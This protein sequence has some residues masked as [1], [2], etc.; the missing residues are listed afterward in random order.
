MTAAA[1]SPSQSRRPPQ[2]NVT[3]PFHMA[4]T[5]PEFAKTKARRGLLSTSRI[6]IKHQSPQKCG[7]GFQEG[8]F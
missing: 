7:C 3:M 4:R 2:L 5:G 1:R 6:H 8:F